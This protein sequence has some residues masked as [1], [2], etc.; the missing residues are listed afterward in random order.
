[1]ICIPTT[2]NTLTQLLHQTKKNFSKRW[3]LL[4]RW[5]NNNKKKQPVTSWNQLMLIMEM[6][7][8][9]SKIYSMRI[10]VNTIE[11]YW[12]QTQKN[13]RKKCLLKKTLLPQMKKKQ[14]VTSWNQLMLITEMHQQMSKIYKQDMNIT[15]NITEMLLSLPC[16]LKLTSWLKEKKL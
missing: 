4:N 9:M 13:L 10:T 2:A 14:I 6:H 1:M 3:F 11:M 8:Q 16:K 7:Q 5:K 12:C 15:A